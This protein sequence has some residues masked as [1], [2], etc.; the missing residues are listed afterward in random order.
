MK[1]KQWIFEIVL[2]IL[3]TT[4]FVATL[5]GGNVRV[6]DYVLMYLALF[7]ELLKNFLNSYCANKE[8]KEETE[9]NDNG[10]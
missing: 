10:H 2:F 4:A 9:E 5:I 1:N 3:W 8:S 6:I 7:L